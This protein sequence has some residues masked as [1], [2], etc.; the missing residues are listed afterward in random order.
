MDNAIVSFYTKELVNKFETE[1]AEKEAKGG[2]V[3]DIVKV[4][5]RYVKII[6]PGSTQQI[7][8]RQSTREDIKKYPEQ[9]EAFSKNQAY[10]DGGVPIEKVPFTNEEQV[11]VLKGCNIHTVEH[12]ANVADVDIKNFGWGGRSLVKAAKDYLQ[13]DKAADEF[14]E[15]KQQQEELM[16]GMRK[17]LDELRK[18]NESTNNSTKRG[19]QN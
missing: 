6:T 13:N 14:K 16:A 12:L 8:D 5:K 7:V 18:K 1:K 2:E 17:E 10:I 4:E 11:R 19:K 9:Y 3:A 15:Y